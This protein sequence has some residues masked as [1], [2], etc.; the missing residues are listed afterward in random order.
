MGNL[1]S[2]NNFSKFNGGYLF[3]KT[4]RPFYYPSAIVQGKIYIQTH[5]PM[6]PKH[7]EIEVSGHEKASYKVRRGDGDDTRDDQDEFKRKIIGFKGI[8]F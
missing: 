1:I 2:K 4:D 6:S 5:V 3:L 8:C 7:I